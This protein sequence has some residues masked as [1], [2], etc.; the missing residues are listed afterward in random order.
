MSGEYFPFP[1]H[2][3]KHHPLPHGHMIASDC[4]HSSHTIP[5]IRRTLFSLVLAVPLT[6]DRCKE[7]KRRETGCR[8]SLKGWK[9]SCPT[10]QPPRRHWG[11]PDCWRRQ[12]AAHVLPGSSSSQVS[13]TTDP[14]GYSVRG[15]TPQL[16]ALKHHGE[17]LADWLGWE[18]G[19]VKRTNN[20]I[21]N[22]ELGELGVQ[23]NQWSL[24]TWSYITVEGLWLN[25]TLLSEPPHHLSVPS[26]E[27][28]TRKWNN[29]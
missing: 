7:R 4:I 11:W 9:Q 13:E 5:V 21:K 19:R 22:L 1:H 16:W 24:G 25:L 28:Y 12:R 10:L 17:P 2:M 23:W 18:R 29:P 20:L 6:E 26:L 14:W 8:F 3:Y 27:S 15:R